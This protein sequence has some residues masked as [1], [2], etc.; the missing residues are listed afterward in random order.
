VG[1]PEGWVMITG[2]TLRSRD[3]RLDP[4]PVFRELR[5]EQPVFFDEVTNSWLITRYDDVS[6]VFADNVHFSNQL[7][8]KTAGAVFGPTMVQYD[9]YEHVALRKV[10]SPEFVGNRLVGYLDVIE[11]ESAALINGFPK[12]PIDLVTEFTTRMP[13]N[14]IVTMLG[15][16]GDDQDRFHDWYRTMMGAL[17]PGKPE[18]TQ[19][20]IEARQQLAHHVAP[21]IE[22]RSECPMGDLISRIIHA[23]ADGRRLTRAEIEAFIS[24]MFV[25]GGETTD[26]AITNTWTNLLRSPDQLALVKGE[27][28]RFDAAFSEM[29]RHSPPVVTQYR[30]TTSEYELHGVT[31]PAG[32][33]VSISIASANNDESVFD[34]PR[35]FD[36]E[37]VDLNLGKEL[38][39]GGSRD[40]DRVG[41]LGFGLGKHFCLGYE[42]ARAETVISSRQ[43]LE[44]FGD[45]VEIGEPHPFLIGDAIRSVASLTIASR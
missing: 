30:T 41:H 31:I 12:A 25:A 20:G 21:A 34:S 22:E 27:P 33:V 18:R 26:K 29:M 10:V 2:E 28:E 39:M 9:G 40:S 7:Y 13:I 32:S 14:V 44:H 17:A 24:L 3:H 8:A 1:E 19:A 16:P 35:R 15:M 43:L 4:W 38:R 5:L 36:L 45:P 11:R 42:M 6:A 23:E 37:R